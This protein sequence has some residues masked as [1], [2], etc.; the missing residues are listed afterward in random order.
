MTSFRAVLGSQ[1]NGEGDAEVLHMLPAPPPA[2]PPSYPHHSPGW[3][4]FLED[5]SQFTLRFALGV[6]HSV[7]LDEWIM[8]CNVT[9]RISL[10]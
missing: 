2:Q 10:P 6:V 5:G 1:R 7:G 9:Q 3:H 4:L 8:A